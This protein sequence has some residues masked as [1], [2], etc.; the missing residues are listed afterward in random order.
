MKQ[1]RVIIGIVLLVISLGISVFS[2][3]TFTAFMHPGGGVQGCGDLTSMGRA[4]HD[5]DGSSGLSTTSFLSISK[6]DIVSTLALSTRAGFY[7]NAITFE[8]SGTNIQCTE[9]EI[10]ASDETTVKAVITKTGD[11]YH[12]VFTEEKLP[13][14]CI[15]GFWML[16]TIVSVLILGVGSLALII[17]G[18]RAKEAK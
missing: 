1:N 14:G 2:F 16:V 3:N 6:G 15:W 11:G 7:E 9:E 4:V 5:L 17:T 8:C 12:V 10:T 18:L 13:M